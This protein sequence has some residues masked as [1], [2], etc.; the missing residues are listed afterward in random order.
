VFRQTTQPF[1]VQL[2]ANDHESNPNQSNQSRLTWQNLTINQVKC[3][4]DYATQTEP[5][6]TSS[7]SRASFASSSSLQKLPPESISYANQITIES[8][9]NCT[10]SDRLVGNDKQS[11]LDD[12]D[13]AEDEEADDEAELT[14]DFPDPIQITQLSVSEIE[15]E[16]DQ[17]VF[18]VLDH[19]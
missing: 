7:S 15:D 3:T 19:C 17:Y 9:L 10:E 14:S 5:S 18:E 13:H 4:R 1:H 12:H 6:L 11:Q 16:C 2:L 8:N